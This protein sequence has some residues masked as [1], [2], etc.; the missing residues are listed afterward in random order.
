M[1]L[2]KTVWH[3]PDL[4]RSETT[5]LFMPIVSNYARWLKPWSHTIISCEPYPLLLLYKCTV[6]IFLHFGSWIQ[7][8]CTGN[9]S[10]VRVIGQSRY[11]YFPSSQSSTTRNCTVEVYND[12]MIQCVLCWLCTIPDNKLFYFTAVSATFLFAFTHH[13]AWSKSVR[14]RTDKN[15][16]VV[17]QCEVPQK[18]TAFPSPCY[19]SPRK[20]NNCPP[21]PPPIKRTGVTRAKS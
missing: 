19:L 6:Y 9:F 10:R 7:I 8:L 12:L 14:L 5:Y 17:Y 3:V 20:D 1:T 21:P 16:K 2:S 13:L 15:K 18:Q 11:N 4:R